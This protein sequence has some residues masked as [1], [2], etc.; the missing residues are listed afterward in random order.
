VLWPQQRP[1]EKVYELRE[2]LGPDA[3]AMRC[4]NIASA[5]H[6]VRV[7]NSAH[8]DEAKT[9]YPFGT[10][11]PGIRLMVGFDPAKGKRTKFAKNPA[12]MLIGVNPANGLHHYIKW[13]R[14]R[15]YNQYDQTKVLV[16]WAR[17]YRCPIA[18]EDN[19]DKDV[20][21]EHL[22]TL[23]PSGA[24]RIICH[25]TTTNKRDPIDGVSRLINLFERRQVRIHTGNCDPAD[26]T[27]LRSELN[28]WPNGMFSDLLMALWVVEFQLALHTQP[29][30]SAVQPVLPGYVTA[31]GLGGYIDLRPYQRRHG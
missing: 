4:R 22:K 2:R 30:A 26:W 21:F 5:G 9:D 29:V 10:P 17:E 15:G 16:N 8:I 28:H 27:A 24:V 6:G 19:Y 11:P 23:D 7:F 31:R 18:M 14:L 13:Q 1:L 12:A 20:Y 3:F 25:T